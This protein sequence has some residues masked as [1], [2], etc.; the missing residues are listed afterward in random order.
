[1][2]GHPPDLQALTGKVLII[3]DEADI[4]SMLSGVLSDEGHKVLTALTAQAGLKLLGKEL[5]DVCFLDVWLPDAD[6]V[7][8]L[9]KI[10]LTGGDASIIMMSGHATIETAV[11]ATRLGAVDFIEKPLSLEKVLLSVQNALRIRQLRSEN[12]N[13]RNR[14][15]QRYRLIGHSK[16]L[17]QIRATIDMVAAR[18]STVLITG[19]NGTGKENVA[20][21]VHEGSHRSKKPFVAINCAAIPEELIESELFGHERGAFTGATGAKRG[22]FEQANGG[23]L[24]LDEIGDMSLKTQSKVLRVLQEQRFERI[25]GDESVSVDVRVIA[26]T[27]KSLP[28]E[29]RKGNFREDLYYRLN[30]IP[31]E[32]PPLRE[33]K[34]DIEALAVHYLDIFCSENGERRKTFERDALERLRAYSWPGN[35]RELKNIMERLSIM[36]HELVIEGRHLPH[37]IGQQ[38]A[39]PSSELDELLVQ[40]DFREARS[41]FEKLFILRKLEDNQGNITRT[42]DAMGM[43]RSHLYRKLKQFGIDQSHDIRTDEERA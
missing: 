25:G 19:E 26:A 41:G 12:Q 24:F 17:E 40:K 3:D 1:M 39:R 42:A 10:R 16:A 7:E 22:K 28:E 4:G 2:N 37:P 38:P 5:P 36:T 6:G 23:T 27:N 29:I 11:R 15:E 31:I 35:I 14:V 33:R 20:R 9:E 34:E 13:L 8:L 30:V 18:N 32:L 43:E 21:N